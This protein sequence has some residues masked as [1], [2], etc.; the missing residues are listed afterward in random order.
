MLFCDT[1]RTQNCW[2]N[3]FSW[4][5]LSCFVSSKTRYLHWIPNTQQNFNFQFSLFSNKEDPRFH[6]PPLVLLLLLLPS[7]SPIV[8][9]S[10]ASLSITLAV[11]SLCFVLWWVFFRT[12]SARPTYLLL[13]SMESHCFLL[14]PPILATPHS[15]PLLYPIKLASFLNSR[16]RILLL[17]LAPLISLILI[18]SWSFRPTSKNDSDFLILLMFS[19]MKFQFPL[20]SVSRWG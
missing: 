11:D 16:V 7:F 3:Q 4:L 20:L 14:L 18:G 8:S 1:N 12:W 6:N 5:H 17:L 15:C 19:M 2:F 10:F 13:A 9:S